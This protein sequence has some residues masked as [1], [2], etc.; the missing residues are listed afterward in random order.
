MRALRTRKYKLIW[1]LADPLPFPFASDLWASSAW[2]DV[3]RRGPDALYGKR[4][5]RAYM[6]RP[7]FELYDLEND[8]DEVHN[9]AG[10]ARHTKTLAELKQKLKTF[11]KDTGDPWLLKW[12]RE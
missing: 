1:N 5:V 2:Q 9:L 3:Y 12:E 4:T 6:H 7:R 10:Q 11:Q 8:P